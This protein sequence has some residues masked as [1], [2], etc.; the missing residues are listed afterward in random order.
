GLGQEGPTRTKTR[1]RSNG[2]T[3]LRLDDGGPGT[4]VGE[5]P[6]AAWSAIETADV[7]LVSCYGAGVSADHRLRTLLQERA[8][9]RAMVWDPHP[10]GA[11][12]VPGCTVVTPNLD[13]ARTLSGMPSAP[14]D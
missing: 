8:A 12:P 5:L 9:G 4:P 10:R 3:L 2:Q 13:E 14:P 6:D 1:V 11:P 7:V